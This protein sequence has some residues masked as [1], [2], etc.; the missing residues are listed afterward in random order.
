[1]LRH[2]FIAFLLICSFLL[3]SCTQALNTAREELGFNSAFDGMSVDEYTYNL[4]LNSELEVTSQILEIQSV[5]DE[6]KSAKLIGNPFV[7]PKNEY[8]NLSIEANYEKFQP[9]NISISGKSFSEELAKNLNE[10]VQNNILKEQMWNGFL[11]AIDEAWKTQIFLE[12][13][14]VSKMA[15][16][17]FGQQPVSRDQL[18][19]VAREIC[20]NLKKFDYDLKS[21]HNYINNYQVLLP[22]AEITTYIL[23]LSTS[24]YPIQQIE[25]LGSGIERYI[26]F[27]SLGDPFSLPKKPALSLSFAFITANSANSP[28][29]LLSSAETGESLNNWLLLNVDNLDVAKFAWDTFLN[30]RKNV[31]ENEIFEINQCKSYSI[32]LID[33]SANINL[34]FSKPIQIICDDAINTA[35]AKLTLDSFIEKPNVSLGS[36][37]FGALTIAVKNTELAASRIETGKKSIIFAS[38]MIDEGN[39]SNFKN[40]ILDFD[41]CQVANEDYLNQKFDLSDF[42][43]IVVGLAN[44]KNELT[45]IEKVRQYWNCYFSAAGTVL[46]ETSDLSGY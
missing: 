34:D 20:I 16:N 11:L 40:K 46:Y 2:V 41:P 31:W 25:A 9:L 1:M 37:V 33:Q 14:C 38:D 28:R 6:V 36:D 21:Y 44:S 45:I 4:D 39:S 26:S 42:E 43:I 12:N 3:T 24:T 13:D 17:Y 5:I 8:I 23:D 19:T 30:I 7:K 15:N 29:I 35:R 10:I 32:S 27:E 22:A 18:T